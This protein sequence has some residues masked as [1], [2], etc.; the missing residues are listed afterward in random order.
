MRAMIDCSDYFRFDDRIA[1]NLLLKASVQG[2][3]LDFVSLY[4]WL[5]RE[6]LVERRKAPRIAAQIRQIARENE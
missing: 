6:S 5:V 3:P 4:D 2:I 1:R